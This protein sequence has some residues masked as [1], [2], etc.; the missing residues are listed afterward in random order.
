VEV[1]Q[2]K[3]GN[4]LEEGRFDVEFYEKATE[5][6]KY[7]SD[8]L[9]P[10]E[11]I[12]TFIKDKRDPREKPLDNFLYADIRSVDVSDGTI[13]PSKLSG[14]EAPS[15]ARMVVRQGDIIISTCRP[16]RK[17]I[18]KIPSELNN[19][20]ASTGFSITKPKSQYNPNFIF[21]ILR[22]DEVA[23]QLGRF[24][25]G[26]SYPAVLEKHIKKV[27]IP[28][29][30]P[31]F[32]ENIAEI[33]E[34][35]YRKRRSK[36]DRIKYLRNSFD[37]GILKQLSI[38][39]KSNELKKV[40]K[41]PIKHLIEAERFDVLSNSNPFDI[42]SYPN[43]PWIQ[44]K[45]ICL[46]PIK[47]KTNFNGDDDEVIYCG[48]PDINAELAT[49]NSQNL[50]S[51]EIKGSKRV[52]KGGDILFAR[53]EPSIYNLKTAMIPSKIDEILCSTELFVVRCNQGINSDY[54]LWLLRSN[55][56]QAQIMGKMTG[57]TGRRRFEHKDLKNFWIPY[58]GAD[59]QKRIGKEYRTYLQKM[60]QLTIEAEQIVMIAKSQVEKM[61]F[62]R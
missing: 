24:S 42:D 9:V 52:A 41:M 19:Q 45:N 21:H 50:N 31:D 22:S 54:I 32:Q 48:V 29:P 55:L 1:F 39:L 60:R 49:I 27:K 6:D 7:P 37:V 62:G 33:M 53:I 35:V 14:K 57:S 17:A 46:T 36:L 34:K 8:M 18:A 38:D 28:I 3:L 51:S 26:T 59:T 10:L 47:N 23:K 16:T 15:R 61:I 5:L 58:P 2:E 56:A 25:S 4:I 43:V 13:T 11:D 40:F 30:S 20:I 12:L 44:L